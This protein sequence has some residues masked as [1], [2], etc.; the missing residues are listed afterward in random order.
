MLDTQAI[1]ARYAADSNPDVSADQ[2]GQVYAQSYIGALD[3]NP[4]LVGQAVEEFD[5]FLTAYFDANP[6]FE[7]ILSS[8]LVSTEDKL[9]II[10]RTVTSGSPM[11]VNFLKVVAKHE[12]MDCLRAIYR[13]MYLQY[14]KMIQRLPITITTAVEISDQE[15]EKIGQSLIAQIGG[16]PIIQR[17]VDPSLI[18]GVVVRV[19]DTVYDGS[20]ATQLKKL[21]ERITGKF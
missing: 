20:V 21:R 10:N 14:E 5:S 13:Q 18:G 19:G 1:D 17:K 2:I 6:K 3:N 11:F 8:R 15:A 4:E 7:E 9:D 16:N 12:R